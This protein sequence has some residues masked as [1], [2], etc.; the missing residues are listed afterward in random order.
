MLVKGGPCVIQ[1]VKH[2]FT[3]ISVD[4]QWNISEDGR[5]V[6]ADR[7]MVCLIPYSSVNS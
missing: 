3:V 4:N 6:L 2:A 1:Y 7:T 5:V